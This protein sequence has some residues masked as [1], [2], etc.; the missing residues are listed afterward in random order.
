MYTN[1]PWVLSYAWPAVMHTNA[2]WD[3]H[4]RTWR[5]PPSLSVGRFAWISEAGGHAWPSYTLVRSILARPHVWDGSAVPAT[6]RDRL[7]VRRS[8]FGFPSAKTLCV[9][10][11]RAYLRRPPRPAD[12][13]GV[14]CADGSAF[15]SVDGDA[16]LGPP[17]R[18]D[19]R[20]PEVYHDTKNGAR[21]RDFASSR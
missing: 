2:P 21:G 20:P 12:S 15:M 17:N 3:E 8:D 11:D 5:N 10:A 9:D 19:F 6:T 18:V 13:R 1:D 16:R 14:L 4:Y 7:G